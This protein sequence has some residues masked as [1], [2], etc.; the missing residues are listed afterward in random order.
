[1]EHNLGD[2]QIKIIGREFVSHSSVRHYYLIRNALWLCRQRGLRVS[3]RFAIAYN[4]FKKFIAYSL[5]MP[6]PWEHFSMMCRGAWH[7]LIGRMG[8]FS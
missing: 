5:F 3:W 2:A 7:G 4:A 1:M 8:R 6:K